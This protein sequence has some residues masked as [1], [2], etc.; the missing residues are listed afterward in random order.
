M[1]KCQ[2][3]VIFPLDLFSIE[4]NYVESHSRHIYI[5]S[6]AMI[7][8]FSSLEI[9]DYNLIPINFSVILKKCIL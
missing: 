9:R 4:I 5:C 3:I 1:N 7:L 6:K 8:K 2:Y